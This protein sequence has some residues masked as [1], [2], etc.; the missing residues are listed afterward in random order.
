[1]HRQTRSDLIANGVKNPDFLQFLKA[2]F[3]NPSFKAVYCYRLS[4]KFFPHGGLRRLLARMLWRHSFKS[5]GCDIRPYCT[6]GDNLRLPHP[7]GVVVGA[8]CV[9]GND[10][11]MYQNVTLGMRDGDRGGFPVINNGVTIYAG[12]C[13][14]GGVTIGENATIGANAVVINDVPEGAVAVGAPA[15]ILP[16]KR[17][18]EKE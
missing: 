9:I 17:A 11:T 7:I 15:R 6:I 10:V 18:P 8:D 3:L 4:S 16:P 1:M 12:A 2:L 13:V 5:C 14:I